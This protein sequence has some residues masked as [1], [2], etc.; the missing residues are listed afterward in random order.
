MSKKKNKKNNK[1]ENEN[2]MPYDFMND[3]PR[4][5][6]NS[7]DDDIYDDSATYSS[8]YYYGF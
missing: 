6:R 5:V 2:K 4:S 3:R 1:K 7:H 8:A